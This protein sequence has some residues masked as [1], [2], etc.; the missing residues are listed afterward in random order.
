MWKRQA[1]F[2]NTAHIGEVPWDQLTG[3][4]ADQPGLY[5]RNVEQPVR[6]R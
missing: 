2:Y 5:S 6:C 4:K 1:D 3:S